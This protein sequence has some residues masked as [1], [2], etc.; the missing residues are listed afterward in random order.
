MIEKSEIHKNICEARADYNKNIT[1]TTFAFLQSII[2][3]N[4]MTMG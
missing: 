1:C 3:P 2:P 4:H